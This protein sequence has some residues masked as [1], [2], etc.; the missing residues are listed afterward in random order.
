VLIIDD[1]QP[2]RA[3]L[4]RYFTR[5]GWAAEQVGDADEALALLRNSP[6]DA[7]DA[8]LS[9]MSMPGMGGPALHD[10]LRDQ[11][12]AYFSRLILTTGDVASPEATEL[13]ERS[14]RPFVAKPFDFAALMELVTRVAREG[15]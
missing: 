4:S 3:A 8:I 9:D 10:A 6:P 14:D 12:P 15:R 5:R 11:F 13:K 7:F 2:V 1:E